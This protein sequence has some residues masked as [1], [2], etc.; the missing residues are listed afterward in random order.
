MDILPEWAPNIHPLLVHF[1]IALLFAAVLLDAIALLFRKKNPALHIGAVIVYV[2]GAL[3][4]LVAFFTGRDAA[5]Q[6]Q[7]PA[8]AQT[9]LTEHADLALWTVWFFGIYALIRIGVLL[10]DKKAR[11]ALWLPLLLVGAG[12]LYLV[13]ETA[14][15]GAQMVF[16]HGVGVQAVTA[17]ADQVATLEQAQRQSRMADATPV[18]TESGSWTWQPVDSL[19][20]DM[21][22][23]MF[24]WLAGSAASAAVRTTEDR[25]SVLVLQPEGTPQF[26]AYDQP[27]ASLQADVSVN[28]DDFNGSLRLTHHVQDAD[29]YSF[30]AVEDGVMKQGRV[31]NGETTIMD[32]KPF[33]PSGWQTLRVVA[34]KTHFRGYAEGSLITHGHGDAPAPGT[35]GL[36][37]EGTGTALVG[38]LDVQSL[39]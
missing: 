22:D 36:R 21:L 4:A 8:A 1:P 24:R 35:V 15:H 2:M 11:V 25:A 12:G 3:G 33:T 37:L 30:L 17:L 29:N 14:E 5:D 13:W 19:N 34:D 39:R 10:F 6:V 9:V 27:L 7:L 31:D 28:L 26:F 23:D 18:V 32:E 20:S 16:Q 38:S